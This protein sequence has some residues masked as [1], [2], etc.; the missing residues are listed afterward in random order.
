M[1]Y[2]FLFALQISFID[3]DLHAVRLSG[4]KRAAFRQTHT[5]GT[6]PCRCRL[7]AHAD[8]PAVHASGCFPRER[9]TQKRLSHMLTAR[10]RVTRK[11]AP[12]LT[13]LRTDHPGSAL[14]HQRTPR[15]DALLPRALQ[16]EACVISGLFPLCCC[17]GPDDERLSV[18]RAAGG[19]G[20]CHFSVPADADFPISP[21]LPERG[22]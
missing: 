21:K 4:F 6:R 11:S 20:F 5:V 1:I 16:C 17:F 7:T 8:S 15:C 10:G 22:C 14:C 13:P 19:L 12:L 3:S 9:K 2:Y 18:C